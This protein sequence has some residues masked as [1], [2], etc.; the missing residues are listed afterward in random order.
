MTW[1]PA[2]LIRKLKWDAGR[3]L[4]SLCT[5]SAIR[6]PSS[7]LL[8]WTVHIS[9]KLFA[10]HMLCIGYIAPSP[11]S[12]KMMLLFETI[13]VNEHMLP[14]NE[15]IYNY[16]D[17]VLLKLDFTR[18][19]LFLE[20]LF[21]GPFLSYILCEFYINCMVPTQTCGK[22]HRKICDIKLVV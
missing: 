13:G 4:C 17:D 7:P 9:N 22:G 15:P 14:T 3:L 6:N 19:Y 2:K 8:G 21:W 16:N 1:P 5:A 12:T 20:H 10:Q 18:K 11:R